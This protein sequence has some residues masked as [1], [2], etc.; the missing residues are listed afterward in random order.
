VGEI[1]DVEVVMI[2]EVGYAGSQPVAPR[3]DRPNTAPGRVRVIHVESQAI[4]NLSV[5]RVI[6]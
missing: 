5:R 4:I 3:G 1:R 6:V 2:I